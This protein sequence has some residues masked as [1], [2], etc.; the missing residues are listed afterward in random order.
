[1]ACALIGH[2]DVKSAVRTILGP[3]HLIVALHWCYCSSHD[4]G[5][6]EKCPLEKQ[7]S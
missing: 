1:M 6:L 2:R 4:F 3:H 7:T 5:M